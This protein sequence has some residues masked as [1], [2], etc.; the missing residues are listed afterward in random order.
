MGQSSL[1]LRPGLTFDDTVGLLIEI[2]ASHIWPATHTMYALRVADRHKTNG[3]AS[4]I[5]LS[6]ASATAYGF[7]AVLQHHATT[8]EAPTH[9]IRMGLVMSLARRPIWLLGN[10]LDGLGYV[11]QFEALRRGSLALVEPILVLSLVVALPVGARLEHRR[12]TWAGLISAGAIATGLGLFLGVARPGVGHPRASVGGWVVLSII[13][14]VFCGTT[15]LAGARSR[16]R[17]GAAVL[18][19]A[20]SGAAFGYTAALTE[21]T[22]HLLDAGLVHCLTCW[23]PYAL[24]IA[25]G[26]ALLLT[27]S[28]YH[29]GALRLSLPILTVMQPL[30]AI[31]ISLAFLGEHVDTQGASSGF[32]L[33]G[34]A[35]VTLGVFG[36]GHSPVIAQMEE[37]F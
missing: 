31:A 37:T 20:G 7:A 12:N 17:R 21:R 2:A 14:G 23:Q 30:V 13:V 34:L 11:L 25:G 6:L 24:L 32:E 4:V 3:L 5:L 16:S 28:A 18:L 35:A 27:Q 26:A 1:G 10:V 36:V 8:K 33:L 29:A 19:A 15:A 22:G 9:S